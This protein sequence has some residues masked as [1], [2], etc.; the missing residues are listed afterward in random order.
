[1]NGLQKISV[2]LG[3]VKLDLCRRWGAD[4]QKLA[5]YFE[6]P[7]ADRARFDKGWEPQRTWEWLES[8]ASW[9]SW[10]RAALYPTGDLPISC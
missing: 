2:D 3:K 1:M 5:D 4:W 8:R 7:A 9:P 10:P 6:I